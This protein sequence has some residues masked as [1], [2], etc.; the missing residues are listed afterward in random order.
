MFLFVFYW[1]SAFNN[2]SFYFIFF[3]AEKDFFE[4][5][6]QTRNRIGKRKDIQESCSVSSEYD[7]TKSPK[8]IDSDEALSPVSSSIFRVERLQNTHGQ[9]FNSH[10]IQK[11][12]NVSHASAERRESAEKTKIRNQM[13]D[14]AP[15]L[16]KVQWLDTI[17]NGKLATKHDINYDEIFDLEIEGKGITFRSIFK[18]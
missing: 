2:F 12:Q 6:T 18:N 7:D 3:I 5:D 13:V 10:K 4:V 1:I 15:R 9:N 16:T 8:K 11:V 17:P 14:D